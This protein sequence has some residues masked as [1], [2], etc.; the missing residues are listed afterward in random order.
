MD[1]IFDDFWPKVTHKI[2]S[3][4]QKQLKSDRKEHWMPSQGFIIL[5]TN[6]YIEI[7]DFSN[8]LT[9]FHDLLQDNKTLKSY[10]IFQDFCPQFGQNTPSVCLHKYNAGSRHLNLGLISE[11]MQYFATLS[12]TLDILDQK[13]TK[14]HKYLYF[15]SKIRPKF[16]I[17]LPIFC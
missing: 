15:F 6:F 10:Y 14:I 8:Y 11:K 9:N 17:L 1:P 7:W 2:N 13:M 3:W 16:E 12:P 5:N 4:G